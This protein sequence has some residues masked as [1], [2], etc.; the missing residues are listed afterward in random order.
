M[1]EIAGFRSRR[2][3]TPHSPADFTDARQD[4]G[5]RLLLSMMMNS[6]AGARSH[7]EQSAPQ[8]RLDAELWRDRRQ[9]H[10]SWRLRRSL[11]E[12]GRTDNADGRICDHVLAGGLFAATPRHVG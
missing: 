12:S 1:N 10:R 7:L 5:D 3:F 8:H 9:A 2:E 4:I 11:I 6:R